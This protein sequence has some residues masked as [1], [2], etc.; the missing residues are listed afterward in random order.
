VKGLKPQPDSKKPGTP[1][2]RT[3]LARKIL[4]ARREHSEAVKSGTETVDGAG[5]HIERLALTENLIDPSGGAT[6]QYGSM[7]GLVGQFFECSYMMSTLD[8]L[9][10]GPMAMVVKE[11]TKEAADA[12]KRQRIEDSWRERDDLMRQM[13]KDLAAKT[14]LQKSTVEAV[15][16]RNPAKMS[17][18]TATKLHHDTKAS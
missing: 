17:A 4:A 15:K 6:S 11:M 14:Q 8:Q 7:I 12:Q 16:T 18:A 3:A 13:L 10:F 1:E 9:Y 5:L 2:E